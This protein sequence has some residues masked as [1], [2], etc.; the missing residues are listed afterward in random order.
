MVNLLTTLTSMLIVFL[1]YCI[2]CEWHYGYL[3]K[4]AAVIVPQLLMKFSIF[5]FDDLFSVNIL[6]FYGF[7]I[8]ECQS[9]LNSCMLYYTKFRHL[10]RFFLL[11][12]WWKL[13]ESTRILKG[14]ASKHAEKL[15]IV[16]LTFLYKG[17]F[18]TLNAL[19]LSSVGF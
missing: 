7:S 10:C 19:S 15:I 11:L 16:V 3:L 9:F 14:E 1:I 6:E 13:I 5:L 2:F 8:Q 12:I 4:A 18:Y 17:F